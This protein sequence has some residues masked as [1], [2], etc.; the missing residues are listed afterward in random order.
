VAC[1]SQRV[2]GTPETRA[3]PRRRCSWND[4]PLCFPPKGRAGIVYALI[5]FSSWASIPTAVGLVL[6]GVALLWALWPR[7]ALSRV[8]GP[9]ETAA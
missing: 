2:G 9:V 6:L 4:R 1:S 5:F 8:A 7:T 3:D